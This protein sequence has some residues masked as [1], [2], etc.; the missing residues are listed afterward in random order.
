MIELDGTQPL[1]LFGTKAGERPFP[2]PYIPEVDV[3]KVL[4]NSIQ[5][6]YLHFIGVII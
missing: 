1:K 3:G 6:I 5:S 2:E 4:V